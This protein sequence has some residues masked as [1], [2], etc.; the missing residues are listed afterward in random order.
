MMP[1]SNLKRPGL[2]HLKEQ[3]PRT[4]PCVARYLTN[5]LDGVHGNVATLL[6][7]RPLV[8]THGPVLEPFSVATCDALSDPW[9]SRPGHQ[10]V[11]DELMQEITTRML[12]TCFEIIEPIKIFVR[13]IPFS[14]TK[15]ERLKIKD[16]AGAKW[17]ISECSEARAGRNRS[18]GGARFETPTD[19]F[20]SRQK[21]FA[22]RKTHEFE[23]GLVVARGLDTQD[24]RA[25]P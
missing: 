13:A 24:A 11:C 10:E 23:T 18:D 6:A 14:C 25:R 4:S 12:A 22:T 1:F 8:S 16:R 3:S 21:K 17:R 15:R 19:V 20:K 2:S 7:E 5:L 9:R